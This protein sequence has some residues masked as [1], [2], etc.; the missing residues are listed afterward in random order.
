[1]KNDVDAHTAAEAHVTPPRT[2]ATFFAVGFHTAWIFCILRNRTV[3]KIE[4][5]LQ[6][7]ELGAN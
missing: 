2:H 6:T 5:P 7:S 4:C 3:R 1:M